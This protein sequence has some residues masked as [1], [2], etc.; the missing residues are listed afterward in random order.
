[1]PDQVCGEQQL[2]AAFADYGKTSRTP[3][4]WV[5]S[6][7]DHFF[8]P[9]LVAELKGAFA[10]AGGNVS[11]VAAPSF[12]DDGHLLFSRPAGIPICAPIVDSFLGSNR[13]WVRDHLIDMPV[14]NVVPP[15]SLGATGRDAFRSYLDSGPN[16]AFVADGSHFGWVSGRR[17]TDEAIKDALGKC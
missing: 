5:S 10:S 12:G 1:L 11:F 8:G 13:L 4:L 3:L 14:V 16:K 7:N 6:P 17:S 15:S 2:V 9:Q